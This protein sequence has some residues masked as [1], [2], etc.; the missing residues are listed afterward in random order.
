V[1]KII[2]DFNVLGIIGLAKNTGKTTTLN[3]I[4]DLFSE[5]KIGLTSIGLDGEELDQVNFLPKPKIEVKPGMIVATASACLDAAT[6]K[7]RLILKTNLFTALGPIKLI[8][9]LTTGH[10][11]VAGPTTNNDLKSLIEM[12]K[13][14]VDK[15]LID[16]AFNRMTF[17]NIDL[18]EGIILATGAIVHP[19]MD[20]TIE[21]TKAIVDAFHAPKSL[22]YDHIPRAK[23]AISTKDAIYLYHQKNYESLKQAIEEHAKEIESIYIQGAI[24]PKMIDLFISKRIERIDFVCDDPTK[25]LLS[26]TYFKHIKTLG[27]KLSVIHACMLVAVTINPFSPN[28]HHYDENE[29]LKRM[30]ENIDIPVF[31]V[32][33]MEETHV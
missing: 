14:R 10:L 6:I 9:V 16:G 8:E 26:E 33:R 5:F 11:V 13:P 27:I 2:K 24:T 23:I 25:L 22:K 19:S 20:K 28:G 21:K 1:E 7:Y 31:N 12:M 18:I 30:K 3:A 29:F 32:R 15:L 17:S 4:I